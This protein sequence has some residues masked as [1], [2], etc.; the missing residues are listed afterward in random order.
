[1]LEFDN[2]YD[3]DKRQGYTTV[4]DGDG[5]GDGW[6]FFDEYIDI[7]SYVEGVGFDD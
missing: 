6:G 7:S 4:D 5:Y 2:S 3:I 1:M